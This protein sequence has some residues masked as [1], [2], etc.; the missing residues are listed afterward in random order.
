MADLLAGARGMRI[1]TVWIVFVLTLAIVGWFDPVALRILALNLCE[2][3]AGYIVGFNADR[4]SFPYA[5]PCAANPD[6]K[7]MK[8]RAKVAVIAGAAVCIAV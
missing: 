3:T 5:R 2:F 7:W 6:P 1:K 8:R 4:G